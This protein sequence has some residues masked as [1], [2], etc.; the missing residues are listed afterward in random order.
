M[1]RTKVSCRHSDGWQQRTHEDRNERLPSVLQKVAPGTELREGIDRIIKAGKGAIIVLGADEKVERLVSGGFRMAASF[2]AQRLSELAK[3]DGAIILDESCGKIVRANV[4]LVPD[5]TIPTAETGTRHRTAERVARQTGAPVVSVSESM[6]IVTLYVDSTKHV[7]KEISSIL[8][9]A[10]QALSML[11]R[12]RNRLDEVSSGL[13]ALE[14]EDVVTLR[15]VVTVLQRAEMVRR[16]AVEI[17]MAIVEL[18]GDGRLLHLQLNELM[19]GVE[20]E[21]QLVVRDYMVDGPR[22]HS[23]I[24]ADFDCMGA[25]QLLD[26]GRFARVLGYAPGDGRIDRPVSPRGYRLLARIPRLSD[27]VIAQLVGR[28]SSLA[29]L[30]DAS[31]SELDQVEGIGEARAR[32][33][34]E[35]LA[36]L[37]ESSILERYA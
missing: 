5:P 12:Y 37:A 28:F 11:E 13:S 10:N 19:L 33:I 27:K 9:R 18:G 34:K 15:D 29:R 22:R 35:G 1:A 3:M 4:H 23:S 31:I 21:R 2:T 20:S 16:I 17:R 25:E 8:F 32:L 36:R 26:L 6:R 24:L 7:L 30:L 14:I